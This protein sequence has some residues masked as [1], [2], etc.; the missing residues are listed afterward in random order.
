MIQYAPA[1]FNKKAKKAVATLKTSNTSYV[2]TSMYMSNW[3][4]LLLI[5][6]NTHWSLPDT[7]NTGGVSGSIG[8]IMQSIHFHAHCGQRKTITSTHVILLIRPLFAAV[9]NK[10]KCLRI[11]RR[12]EEL[13][14]SGRTETKQQISPM[15]IC[16]SKSL[17]VVWLLCF[18]NVPRY[19]R[20]RL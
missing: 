5:F 7:W 16:L 9:T 1:L 20:E 3:F 15:Y 14:L 6:I 8:R 19:L 4:Y 13:K 10:Q 18:G 12:V 2:T 17:S 11:G